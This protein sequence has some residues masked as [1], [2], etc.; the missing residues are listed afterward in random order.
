ML[1]L[2]AGA[3]INVILNLILIPMIGIEGA[4]IATLIDYAASDFICVFTLYKMKLQVIDTRFVGCC[5]LMAAFI[6]VWRLVAIDNM[7]L[8]LFLSVIG[9][10]IM[11]C[12]YRNDI[13]KFLKG[14]K[15]S[16]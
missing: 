3:I 4:A 16:A 5:I 12:L 13:G 8:S 7:L 15:K 1:I 10:G 11:V 14:V 2:S 6:I 9:S